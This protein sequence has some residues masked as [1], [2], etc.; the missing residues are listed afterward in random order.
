MNMTNQSPPTADEILAMVKGV[1]KTPSTDHASVLNKW[2][3]REQRIRT[4]SPWAIWSRGQTGKGWCNSKAY[5]V[6]ATTAQIMAVQDALEFL[7]PFRDKESDY[8]WSIIGSDNYQAVKLMRLTDE[9]PE[10]A[11][12]PACNVAN[13]MAWAEHFLRGMGDK[14]T[15]DKALALGWAMRRIWNK[16]GTWR[17][18][19][20]LG[21]AQPPAP[22]WDVSTPVDINKGDLISTVAVGLDIGTLTLANG[23]SLQMPHD[24][25]SVDITIHE[26]EVYL[27][28]CMSGPEAPKEV[29]TFVPPVTP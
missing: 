1:Q 16:R 6:E 24:V 7:Q 18:D 25:R 14:I 26:G 11:T 19:K 20:D 5:E 29:Q 8:L 22:Q 9:S 3:E 15:P 23:V 13:H 4:N 27:R 17:K 21:R 12:G 10:A 28:F 2:R